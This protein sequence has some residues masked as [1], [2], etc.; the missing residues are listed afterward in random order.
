M[1]ERRKMLISPVVAAV[2]RDKRLNGPC[3]QVVNHLLELTVLMLQKC[4]TMFE[5]RE[6][7]FGDGTCVSPTALLTNCVSK[8][9]RLI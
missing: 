7:L 1:L 6:R 8:Y 4:D 3:T 5:C 9:V 2:W